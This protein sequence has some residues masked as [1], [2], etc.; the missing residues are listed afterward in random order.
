MIK[1][2]TEPVLIK[3]VK[4]F[5]VWEQTTEMCTKWQIRW[6]DTE[7]KFEYRDGTAGEWEDMEWDCWLG[8]SSHGKLDVLDTLRNL[9]SLLEIS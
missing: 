7:C 1:T 5:P 4:T 6:N 2:I 8:P 9:A 3:T